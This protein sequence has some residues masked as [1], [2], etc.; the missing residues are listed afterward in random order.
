MQGHHHR[1]RRRALDGPFAFGYPFTKD[2]VTYRE[3]LSC[4]AALLGRRYDADRAQSGEAF[5][6]CPET[7]GMNSIVIRQQNI[8]HVACGETQPGVTSQGRQSAEWFLHKSG[9][10]DWI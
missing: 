8:G 4:S 9:R 6:K 3:R 2:G 5:D 10:D 1:I 7:W